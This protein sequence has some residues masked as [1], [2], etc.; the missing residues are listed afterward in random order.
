M[1]DQTVDRVMDKENRKNGRLAL[2]LA[3]LALLVALSSIR[4]WEQLAATA[5]P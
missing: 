5:L 1:V 4:F 2:M 3:G